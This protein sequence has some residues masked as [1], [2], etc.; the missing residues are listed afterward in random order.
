MSEKL[1]DL[2]CLV[3][4]LQE[5]LEERNR[6]LFTVAETADR[7]SVSKPTVR[8]FLQRGRLKLVKVGGSVRV[9][10][11]SLADFIAGRR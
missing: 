6:R 8:R 5:V 10:V 9:E 4:E 1:S 11:G 7:L 3:N 2:S